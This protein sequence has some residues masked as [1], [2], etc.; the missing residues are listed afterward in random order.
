MHKGFNIC[1]FP[2]NGVLGEIT[3]KLWVYGWKGER[4][5]AVIDCA[6]LAPLLPRALPRSQSQGNSPLLSPFHDPKISLTLETPTSGST[7]FLALP[8]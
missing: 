2:V 5:P 8:S 7:E 1:P 6:V 3:Y 4:P